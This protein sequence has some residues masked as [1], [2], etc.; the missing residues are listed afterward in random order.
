MPDLQSELSKLASAWD[1]H[2]QTIRITNQQQEKMVQKFTVTGNA[3]RDT[4]EFI[5]LNGHV[6]TH[7]SA[8]KAMAQ[9]GYK[10]SSVHA[11]LTQMKRAG[12]IQL[13]SDGHV[14]TTMD[15]YKPLH[16]PYKANPVGRP[17]KA[18]TK[19]KRSATSAGI[20]ALQVA[21]E[22][23]PIERKQLVLKLT[24][25]DVLNKLD[26]KEAFKLYQELAKMFGG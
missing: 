15:E 22:Q 3:T 7:S 1:S 5:R 12:M 23:T 20:A 21:E 17:P 18:K 13:N 2:E 4:F 19:A 6:H 14:F 8:A 16:N 25:E 11:V 10:H 24:T 9:L 26:V